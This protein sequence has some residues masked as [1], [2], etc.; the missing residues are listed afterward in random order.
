MSSCACTEHTL[1][2]VC[3]HYTYTRGYWKRTCAAALMIMMMMELLQRNPPVHEAGTKLYM[4]N[5][6][7]LALS[8]SPYTQY[9]GQQQSG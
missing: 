8:H 1:R 2:V 4:Y 7:R 3:R 5:C 6:A 9:R